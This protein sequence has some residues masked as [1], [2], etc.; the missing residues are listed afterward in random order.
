MTSDSKSDDILRK[1]NRIVQSN[2][3][4]TLAVSQMFST[5]SK[6]MEILHEQGKARDVRNKAYEAQ[7]IA[8]LRQLSSAYDRL[9]FL[10]HC[11]NS[12]IKQRAKHIADGM[13]GEQK[14]TDN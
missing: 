3:K 9:L 10:K 2:T 4:V 7:V 14:N 11:E 6:G 13:I 5:L 12:L 1:I 8:G